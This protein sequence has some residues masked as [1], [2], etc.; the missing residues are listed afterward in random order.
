MKGNTLHNEM[1]CFDVELSSNS[2]VG[3]T[4]FK[5]VNR[6]HVVPGELKK[7]VSFS[8][9]NGSKNPNYQNTYKRLHTFEKLFWSPGLSQKPHDLAHAGFFYTGNIK[10]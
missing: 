7:R 4:T 9:E 1:S 10:T 3:S 6:S 5:N 8:D 2:T